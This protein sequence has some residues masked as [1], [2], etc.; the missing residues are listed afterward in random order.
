MIKNMIMFNQQA[1]EITERLEDVHMYGSGSSGNSLYI[2]PY[3]VII[4]LGLPFKRYDESIF[5]DIKYILL[6]H[7]HGDHF[8]IATIT[9]ISNNFPHIT[10][11][12]SEYLYESA[13]EK[14]KA[15]GK[16]F[17]KINYQILTDEP[18]VYEV[19][20]D[21]Y[22]LIRHT[23]TDHGDLVNVSY[24]IKGFIPVDHIETP[25]ILYAS[26][27]TT[28]EPKLKTEGLPK[29]EIYNLMF[30]EANYSAEEV[31]EVLQ[32]D[33]N[34]RKALGNLRH[35]SEDAAFNYVRRYLDKDNGIFIPLH[36]SSEFGTFV[37]K[38][39]DE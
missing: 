15:K 21:N 31:F 4:D 13:V 35:L 29:D 17:E 28:T 8:N 32:E 39:R 36:G 16:D 11:V 30:L 18:I 5:Y 27:L 26:D 34:D 20:E 9:K 38:N 22:A 25:V 12:L 24:T 23:L 33:P 37:Q 19:S 2:K 1:E 3:R 6:T 10:F 14:F 7:E